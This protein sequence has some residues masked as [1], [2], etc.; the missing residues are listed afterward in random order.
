MG[1]V[2]IGRHHGFNPALILPRFSGELATIAVK[3]QSLPSDSIG[4]DAHNVLT[5]VALISPQRGDDRATIEPR[6]CV[7]R[8]SCL[9]V[10]HCPMKINASR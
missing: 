6:S 7:D 9:Y 10:V 5:I 8:G 2:S 1:V 3:L 4:R